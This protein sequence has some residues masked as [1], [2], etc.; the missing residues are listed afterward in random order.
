MV[1]SMCSSKYTIFNTLW[2]KYFFKRVDFGLTCAG[3]APQQR[4]DQVLSD[5]KRVTG[6]SDDILEWGNTIAE[7]DTALLQ[8]LHRCEDVGI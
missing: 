6:I 3:D 7:H 4:L 5:L 1:N 2:G 8:L